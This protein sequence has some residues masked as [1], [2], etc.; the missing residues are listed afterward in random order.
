[1]GYIDPEPLEEIFWTVVTYG[2]TLMAV[3]VF[4]IIWE[5]LL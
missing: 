5:V 1:M 4:W 2:L 3:G